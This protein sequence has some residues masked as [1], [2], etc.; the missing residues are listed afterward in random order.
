MTVGKP[1]V[2]A[3]SGVKNAGKTTL[4]E[5][6]LPHLNAAGL[7]TAVIKHDGHA[8]QADPPDTDTGRH[9]GAG[10]CGVAIFDGEKCKVIRRGPVEAGGL[11]S[12][13]P[14][15]DLILLEGLKA[16]PWPKLEVVRAGNSEGPV[17]APETVLAYVTDLPLEEEGK[18][19]LP[20]NDPAAVAAW[21]VSYIRKQRGE[22]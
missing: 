1:V 4:I 8:F 6:M 14:E 22:N 9:F 18:A 20:L 15:A 21:L 7:S 16:S 3:V 19:V 12:L 17:C 5:T 13:F 11:L 2:V 10:A